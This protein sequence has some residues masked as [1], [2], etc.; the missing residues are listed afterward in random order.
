[1]SEYMDKDRYHKVLKDLTNLLS[2]YDF[3]ELPS[4]QPKNWFQRQ[5]QTLFMWLLNERDGAKLT[6]NTYAYPP[7]PFYGK[8]FKILKKI[9]PIKTKRKYDDDLHFVHRGNGKSQV[10]GMDNITR[11]LKI[12][13]LLEPS[14]LNYNNDLIEKAVKKI[15]K[16]IVVTLCPF[17]KY[18]VDY[19]NKKGATYQNFFDTLEE[20]EMFL[21]EKDPYF[22]AGYR[23]KRLN[24]I[25]T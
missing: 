5:K 7:K 10:F 14:N 24:G 3:Y 2:V 18:K 9:S 1:M 13:R 12:G 20:I 6:R 23:E 4:I 19:Y 11:R 16:E 25:L 15:D 8:I 21:I 22:K 17:N